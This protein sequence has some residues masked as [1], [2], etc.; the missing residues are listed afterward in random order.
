[1]FQNQKL[2]INLRELSLER[3]SL[4]TIRYKKGFVA[5]QFPGKKET[6]E[7]YFDDGWMVA[8]SF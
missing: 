4:Y 7:R 2:H 5:S 3:L 6:K 8:L 1:M